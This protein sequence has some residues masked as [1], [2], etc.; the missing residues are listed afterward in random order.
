[1]GRKKKE[2]VVEKQPE[3]NVDQLGVDILST[4][5]DVAWADVPPPPEVKI[6]KEEEPKQREQTVKRVKPKEEA[7]VNTPAPKEKRE[8]VD[9]FEYI[10]LP[11]RVDLSNFKV[12]LPGRNVFRTVKE[13][14]S[15]YSLVNSYLQGFDFDELSASDI[16]DV[17]NL[18]K[19]KVLE[20]RL[21]AASVEDSKGIL[22]ISTT[23][24]K[25]RKHSATIKGNLS[26]R[27]VDRI[28]PKSKQNFS[29]VDIVFAYDDKMKQDFQKRI[30]DMEKEKED[31]LDSRSK[32]DN[33]NK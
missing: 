16:E 23:I 21:L 2:V 15:F 18:A 27:R 30:K 26:N 3:Q 7:V 1:L 11:D 24:E 8:A 29:I 19:N 13:E 12:F 20:E 5:A 10:K 33:I 31:Y 9:P 4:I 32:R 22:D 25:L 14:K 28:D 6:G 17:I